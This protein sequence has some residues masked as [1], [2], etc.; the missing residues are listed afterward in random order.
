MSIVTAV[1]SHLFVG[2]WLYT[3]QVHILTH[4]LFHLYPQ[5]NLVKDR[6]PDDSESEI[7]V[8]EHH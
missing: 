3:A 5:Q 8:S 1:I 6:K 7:Q 4:T 2:F